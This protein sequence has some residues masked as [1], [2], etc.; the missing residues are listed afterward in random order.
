V[1]NIM[2]WK[3]LPPII[4][5]LLIV[6]LG[7]SQPQAAAT[8]A[9]QIASVTVASPSERP[10]V[11]GGPG[12]DDPAQFTCT[13][14]S[15]RVLVLM[16]WDLKLLYRLSGPLSMDES[17]YD[18]T[19]KIAPGTSKE[20]FNLTLQHLLAERIGLVVHHEGQDQTVYELVISK[21]G[22]KMHEAQPAP[23]GRSPADP[24]PSPD[25]YPPTLIRDNDGNLQLPPGHP[26]VFVTSSSGG[27]RLMA[28][29]QGMPEVV[30]ALEG[31]AGHPI[32]DKTGLTGKY[33]YTLEFAPDMATVHSINQA[34]STAPFFD[35]VE[36]QLGLKLEPKKAPVD[37]LI[38]D[39]FNKVP[40]E[41]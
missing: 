30:G 35:A 26:M 10:T 11:R 36:Q 9:F 38:V 14:L 41:H 12:T 25:G 27:L 5:A 3:I 34:S 7:R 1:L 22:L 23:A 4:L 20:T 17:H 37:V 39:R 28:R 33:D 31:R 32:I 16:A 19:A 24:S 8:S 18:I 2:T 13:N 40:T 29:M 15:L 6:P 21:S